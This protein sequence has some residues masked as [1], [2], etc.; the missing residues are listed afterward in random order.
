[1]ASNSTEGPKA[2]MHSRESIVIGHLEESFD[3]FDRESE[4]NKRLYQYLKVLTLIAGGSVTVAAALSAPPLFTATIGAL[5][6]LIEGVQ[7]LF[8]YHDRWLSFRT[9]AESL[10]REKFLY[11]VAAPPYGPQPDPAL[12][13]ERIEAILATEVATFEAFEKPRVINA[14]RGR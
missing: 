11:S 1:M 5:L 12:L 13:A 2:P 7:Q 14:P 9:T 10:K 6:V 3:R 8:R 4:V